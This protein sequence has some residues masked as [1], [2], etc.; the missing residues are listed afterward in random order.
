MSLDP[1]FL[2]AD[3]GLGE[4]VGMELPM[5][6][7]AE[8]L[9]GRDL[10]EYLGAEGQG[11]GEMTVEPADGEEETEER[12]RAEEKWDRLEREFEVREMLEE[13]KRL[14]QE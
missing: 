10:G 3:T 12:A 11:D 4:L 14:E 1:A 6:L 2:P 9:F 13:L 8:H 5:G 7:R